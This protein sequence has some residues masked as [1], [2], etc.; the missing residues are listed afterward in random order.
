MLEFLQEFMKFIIIKNFELIK[1][2]HRKY[3]RNKSC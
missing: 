3:W 1:V 2:N